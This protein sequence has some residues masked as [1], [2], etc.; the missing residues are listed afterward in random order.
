MNPHE[1]KHSIKKLPKSQIALEVQLPAQDLENKRSAA[2]AALAKDVRLEGFRPGHVPAEVAEKHLG[3]AAVLSE[4]ARLAISEAYLRIV[5]Q[6][7][8]DAIGEPEVRVTKLAFGPPAGGLEFRVQVAVL[9]DVELPDYKKIALFAQ[10]KTVSVQ[11]KE[12]D[13]ALEWLRKS[14]GASAATN[15]FAKNVGNFSDLA[16]LRASIQEGLQHEKELQERDRLRQEIVEQV[17]RQSKLEVPDVLV[18]REKQVL[19]SQVKQGIGQVLRMSFEEYKQKAGKTQQELRDSFS[20]EAEQRIKRFLVIREVAKRERISPTQ[21][22]IEQEAQAIL[23]HLAPPAGRAGSAEQ[24]RLGARQAKQALDPERLKE[25]TEGVL[26]HE[27]T[28]QFLESFVK[29]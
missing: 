19:L 3:E 18:E 25:Y 11:E 27:K 1:M 2:V 26:R 13:E 21:E 16:S 15:E 12:V 10:K 5:E 6:E 17:A 14:R 28:L 7:R 24:T 9:P 29:S 23:Q 8:L 4:A 20:Q 22:E